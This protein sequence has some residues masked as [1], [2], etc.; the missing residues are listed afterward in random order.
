MAELEVMTDEAARAGIYVMAHAHG[1]DGIK[2][3]IRAGVKSIEHGT[4]LDDEAIELMVRNGTWLVPTLGVGQ[5]IIDMIERGA[6]VPAGIAEKAQAN[7]EMRAGSFSR[8]V[9]AGVRIAMGSDSAGESHGNNLIELR[10][11]NELG[12]SGLQVLHAATGSAATLMN[13]A[14]QVGF[15]RPGHQADLTIV[16]GDPLDFG[17]YPANVRAVYRKGAQVRGR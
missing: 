5:F 17:A 1:V 13:I 12:L 3:A 6:S 10:L 14:D 2:N 11:M 15:V 4:Q 7:V 8:A 16:D 9:A